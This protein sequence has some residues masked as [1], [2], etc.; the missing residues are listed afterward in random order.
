MSQVGQNVQAVRDAI[1]AMRTGSGDYAALK[2]AVEQARFATRPTARSEEELAEAWEYTPVEDSFTDTVS[3][4]R[5]QRVLT[6][7]QEKELRGMAQFVGPDTTRL[8]QSVPS[9]ES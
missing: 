7:E 8:T 5:W 4:A 1:Q 6:P 9:Q 2:A 3:A